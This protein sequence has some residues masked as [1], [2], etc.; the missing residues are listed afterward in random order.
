MPST[1]TRGHCFPPAAFL[2]GEGDWTSRGKKLR[3]GSLTR[4]GRACPEQLR[5]AA[6]LLGLDFL[7]PQPTQRP[8]LHTY[9]SRHTH[10]PLVGDKDTPHPGR[11]PPPS[12]NSLSSSSHSCRQTHHIFHSNREARK[13]SS[14]TGRTP[15]PRHRWPQEKCPKA[16]T[17]A[18]HSILNP[19]PKD[20]TPPCITPHSAFTLCVATG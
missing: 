6:H 15:P 14:R 8:T 11:L 16:N 18:R 13:A 10:S 12:A 7:P 20:S 5:R 9:T 2:E 17:L 4:K 3:Q 19:L 1:P